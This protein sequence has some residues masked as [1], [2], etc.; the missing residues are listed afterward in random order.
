MWVTHFELRCL[1]NEKSENNEKSGLDMVATRLMRAREAVLELPH[2][3]HINALFA[4]RFLPRRMTRNSGVGEEES[5]ATFA[6]NVLRWLLSSNSFLAR[7]FPSLAKRFSSSSLETLDHVPQVMWVPIYLAME[8]FNLLPRGVKESWWPWAPPVSF[9]ADWVD[10][11]PEHVDNAAH[12]TADDISYARQFLPALDV[13]NLNA[14]WRVMQA[15]PDN[16]LQSQDQL[17]WG[18]SMMLSRSFRDIKGQVVMLPIADLFN[19]DHFDP[20]VEGRVEPVTPMTF[21]VTDP[22]AF[23]TLRDVEKGSPLRISYGQRPNIELLQMYG[24]VVP[25]NP[26]DWFPLQ[27]V[28]L[29]SSVPAWRHS[30]VGRIWGGGEKSPRVSLNLTWTGASP[31]GLVRFL[32]ASDAEITSSSFVA[33]CASDVGFAFGSFTQ[34]LCRKELNDYYSGRFQRRR[35]FRMLFKERAEMLKKCAATK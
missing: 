32:S 15:M 11:M 25:H 34:R 6:S 35:N 17:R 12:W 20:N 30:V 2:S 1:D 19:H 27:A 18:Y 3:L 16:P 7:W 21:D 33:S 23:V 29:D 31:A 4:S 5:F 28:S 13:H 24:F 14:T 9:L 8:R 26:L 22:I 10:M